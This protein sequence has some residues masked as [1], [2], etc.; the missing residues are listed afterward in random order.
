MFHRFTSASSTVNVNVLIKF[1]NK[2]FVKPSCEYVSP[3][4]LP[5]SPAVRNYC[6]PQG[7]LEADMGSR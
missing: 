6:L 5:L 7:K 1:V 4:V 2:D 3:G